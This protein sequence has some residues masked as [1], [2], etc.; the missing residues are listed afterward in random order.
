MKTNVA[1]A[2]PQP[3]THEGAPAARLTPEQEL[4]GKAVASV[5]A[6][7]K[8]DRLVVLTDE[9][10]ADVVPA[11]LGRGYVINVASAKNGVGY[12]SWQHID[13]WSEAVIDY[14]RELEQ[15][16]VV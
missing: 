6:E 7:C 2:Y 15:L 16:E 14:L 11:P 1:R 10:S 8:Y 3:V 4:L 9:Q 13:G 5:N 12:G